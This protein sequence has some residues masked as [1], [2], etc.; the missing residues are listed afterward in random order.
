M[1]ET[2]CDHL[3]ESASLGLL[4]PN[5]AI[6]GSDVITEPDRGSSSCRGL[7]E[8]IHLIL[9]GSGLR[10]R[11]FSPWLV[12]KSRKLSV[13]TAMLRH[14][15][16]EEL[17]IYPKVWVVTLLNRADLLSQRHALRSRQHWMRLEDLC[18]VRRSG[19]V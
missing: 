5:L 14:S 9:A 15:L 1:A 18:G 3:L 17:S 13:A 19:F 10:H 11:I 7:G 6:L 4:G 2:L 16:L 12:V 8:M